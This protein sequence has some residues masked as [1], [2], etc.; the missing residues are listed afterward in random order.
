MGP[1]YR[2]VRKH[3]DLTLEIRECDHMSTT[4]PNKTLAWLEAKVRNVLR[5]QRLNANLDER[6]QCAKRCLVKRSLSPVPPRRH[7]RPSRRVAHQRPISQRRRVDRRHQ[8]VPQRAAV[9][10]VERTTVNKERSKAEA[11]VTSRRIFPWKRI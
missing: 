8:T 4:D 6:D 1:Y 11:G 10:R 2:K 5:A 9:N 3:P 7:L